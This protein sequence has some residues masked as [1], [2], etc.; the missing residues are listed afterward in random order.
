MLTD[1]LLGVLVVEVGAGIA[2]LV[3]RP[4]RGAQTRSER[5]P[6]A[7]LSEP[8]AASACTLLRRQGDAWVPFAERASVTRDVAKALSTR[9]LAV[10]YP[11]G[12]ID[13][14]VQ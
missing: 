7:S 13:E 3:R 14:G 6:V 10:R 9:G 11:D 8:P 5:A 1:I 2:L 4:Q 12:R